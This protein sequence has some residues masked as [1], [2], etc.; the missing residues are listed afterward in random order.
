M[1]KKYKNGSI[2]VCVFLIGVFVIYNGYFKK[3]ANTEISQENG[4][5]VKIER[6]TVDLTIDIVGTTQIQNEQKLQFTTSGI[7][8]KSYFES[9]DQVVSGDIIAEIDSTQARNEIERSQ[10]VI[11]NATI[12]FNS[13]VSNVQNTGL[14]KSNITIAN[15]HS[16][17]IQKKLDIDYLSEQ[18][19]QIIVQ[20]NFDL[21]EAKN[22]YKILEKEVKKNI[23]TYT[24]SDADKENIIHSKQL[25][26]EQKRSQY[27]SEEEKIDTTVV[28]SINDYNKMLE[29]NYLLIQ[30]NITNTKQSLDEISAILGRN[31]ANRDF[32]YTYLYSKKESKHISNM[33]SQLLQAKAELKILEISFQEIESRT[34]VKSIITT[35]ENNKTLYNS[36]FILT[37]TVIQW[38]QNSIVSIN[39]TQEI[40][41]SYITKYTAHRNEYSANIT[42]LSSTIYTLGLLDSSEKIKADVLNKLS[43]QKSALE[44]LEIEFEKMKENQDFL[45]D[46]S[47]FHSDNQWIKLQKAKSKLK[48]QIQDVKKIEATQIQKYKQAELALQ[49]LE[50]SY[51]K[52]VSDGEKLKNI[53]NNEDYILLKNELRQSEIALSNSYKQLENYFIK[54]PFSGII[55]SMDVHLWDRLSADTKKF[56]ALQNPNLIEINLNISQGDIVKIE[57]GM[58]ILYTF[59]SYPDISFT[60]SIDQ[61]Q[62]SPIQENGVSKY[63]VSSYAQKPEGIKIYSWMKASVKIVTHTLDNVL[64]VPSLSVQTDK[65]WRKSVTVVNEQGEHIS[66]IIETWFSDGKNYEVLSGLQEWEKILLIDYNS[67]EAQS[68]KAVNEQTEDVF[69]EEWF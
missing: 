56:I 28:Q 46:T 2:I 26:I 29:Q 41:D 7:V 52:H 45:T 50:N 53:W 25:E 60:G 61:I 12:K 30:S 33:K 19:K 65:V 21:E 35:L 40:V 67:D 69:G 24:L 59:D 23:N 36:L 44:S 16:Q 55:T 14:E 3:S 4:E 39:F 11:E 62:S 31:S 49:E 32:K 10:L 6:K 22:N 37:N 34:D 54:A 15:L 47:Q 68:A 1:D 17:I 43:I 48:V 5:M 63:K 9:G 58:K 27:H 20:A 13:F 51:K 57:K 64:L 38:F 42:S 66:R 18:Q 8:T